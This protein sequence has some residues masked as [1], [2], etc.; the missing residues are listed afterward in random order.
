[1]HP[2]THT[3]K[4]FARTHLPVGWQGNPLK[5]LEWPRSRLAATWTPRLAWWRNL[6][7][8]PSPASQKAFLAKE[9]SLSSGTFWFLEEPLSPA[10]TS[11]VWRLGWG[12]FA[13]LL[14]LW[15]SVSDGE[16]LWACSRQGG[17][18]DTLCPLSLRCKKSIRLA[19]KKNK[20]VLC[21]EKKKD[22]EEM[23]R[24]GFRNHDFYCIPRVGNQT[25]THTHTHTHSQSVIFSYTS[26]TKLKRTWTTSFPNRQSAS[27]SFASATA[28]PRC[29]RSFL[30]EGSPSLLQTKR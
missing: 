13:V 23:G 29:F 18:K 12:L 30:F 2:H 26:C 19:E 22:W 1:M 14:C 15:L 8:V 7:K 3:P 4:D 17:D 20:K 11:A 16:L 24:L 21:R 27:H 10:C 6:G 28:S 9:T 25:H 5:Q